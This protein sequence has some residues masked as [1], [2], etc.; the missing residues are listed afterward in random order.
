MY[1]DEVKKYVIN[2]HLDGSCTIKIYNGGVY[3]EEMFII[4]RT[5]KDAEKIAKNIFP[6][7][8]EIK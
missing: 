3:F 1:T 4:W 8:T 5:R 6:S 7:A 2:E